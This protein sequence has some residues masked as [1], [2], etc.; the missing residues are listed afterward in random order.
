MGAMTRHSLSTVR[1]A[2][3]PAAFMESMNRSSVYEMKRVWLY[4]VGVDVR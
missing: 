3:K 1:L 4:R 2:V